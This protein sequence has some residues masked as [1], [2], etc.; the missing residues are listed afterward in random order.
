MSKKFKQLY[1]QAVTFFQQG[2]YLAAEPLFYQLIEMQPKNETVCYLL[3]TL[4]CQLAQFEEGV[5]FLKKVIEINPNQTDALNNLGLALATQGNLEEAEQCYRRALKLKPGYAHAWNN[6]GG[7]CDAKKD[8]HESILCYQKA[9]VLKANYS[10]ALYNLGKALLNLE[11]YGEAEKNLLQ[12]I[13]LNPEHY[14]ALNNMAGLLKLQNRA[15]QALPYLQTALQVNPERF[16]AYNNIAAIYQ[17]LNRS[18]DSLTYYDKALTIEPNGAQVHANR[19]VVLLSLGRLAEGWDEHEWRK[20]AENWAPFSYPEWQGED[21]SDKTIVVFAEQGVGD[22]ILFAS[23]LADLI[24]HA[25]LCIIECDPR[26]ETLYARSF[27]EAIVKGSPRSEQGWLADYPDIS[28]CTAIGSL[29]R[30]FRQS[31]NDFPSDAAV[32]SEDKERH[33]YW[34]KE[35]D[36]L[37]AGIKVGICWRSRLSKEGRHF[38][39][40]QLDDWGA[41]FKVPGVTFINLQYDECE[42]ELA[43]ANKL[44]GINIHQFDNI[45]LMNDLDDLVALS[46]CLDLVI[47][48]GT[49]TAELA[50]SIGTP[51]FRINPT[52]ID[53]G[54]LGTKKWP[55][56]PNTRIFHQ[57]EHEQWEYPLQLIADQ[58]ATFE[59]QEVTPHSNTNQMFSL[60]ETGQG[61]EFAWKAYRRGNLDTAANA[62]QQFMLEVPDNARAIE[63]Q[64]MVELTRNDHLKAENNFRR[65]IE[66]SPDTAVLYTR[67][68]KV[69]LTQGKQQEAELLFLQALELWSDWAELHNDLANL[70]YE[71]KRYSQ[72][73]EHYLLALRYK[74]DLV[75]AHN[76]LGSMLLELKRIDEAIR[77]F[78]DALRLKPHFSE[79]HYNLAN[80][81]TDKGDLDQAVLCFKKALQYKPNFSQAQL[82][83]AETYAK[84]GEFEMAVDHYI[85]LQQSEPD[86]DQAC[87]GL[88]RINVKQNNFAEGEQYYLKA[89]SLK[90]G[91]LEIYSEL[92][93]LF[94][95]QGRL[96]EA[97]AQ[98]RQAIKIDDSFYALHVNL[99]VILDA[100]EQYQEAELSFLKA[101]EIKPGSS[102]TYASLGKLFI[103]TRSYSEAEAYCRKAIELNPSS[104]LGYINLSYVMQMLGQ[105][106]Q[107]IDLCHQ[108]VERCDGDLLLFKNLIT[109]LFELGRF[110]ECLT[111]CNI[112]LSELPDDYEAL[113]CTTFSLLS[114]GELTPGWE[115][116][117]KLQLQHSCVREFSYPQWQGESLKGTLL[118]FAWQ[119]I[120]DELVFASCLPDVIDQ[121]G[122]C[123]I[124]CEPRLRGLYERSFPTAEVY[125]ANRDDK[126]WLNKVGTIDAQIQID[127]LPSIVRKTLSDFPVERRAYLQALPERCKYW[128]ERV[129]AIGPGL[130]IGIA[131]R[132]GLLTGGRDLYYSRIEHWKSVFAIPGV[133][134]INLQYDECAEELAQARKDFSVEITDFSE[135]NLKQDLEEAAALSS[136]MDIVISAGTA[137]AEIAA[138]I[139]VEVWRIEPFNLSWD[140]LG[141]GQMP[142]HS[143]MRIFKCPELGNW[144]GVLNEI[145]QEVIIYSRDQ[146]NKINH[147]N[148]CCWDL[149]ALSFTSST[150][151]AQ[152]QYCYQQSNWLEVR[153]LGKRLVSRQPDDAS[154]IHLMGKAAFKE[155][156]LADAQILMQQAQK[157]K[158]DNAEILYELGMVMQECR[159][160]KGA[161]ESYYS[162]LEIKPS[163]FQVHNNLGNVLVEQNQVDEAEKHY[164]SAI[165]LKPED[166]CG[167]NNLGVLLKKQNRLEEAVDCYRQSLSICPESY[168]V[169]AN[170]G[171]VLLDLGDLEEAEKC[172]LQAEKLNNTD[173]SVYSGLGDTLRE[174][175]R[176]PESLAY[177][178]KAIELDP[179]NDETRWNVA[180]TL[181]AMGN[182]KEGW[183][184]YEWRFRTGR[185]NRQFPYPEWDGS[186]L[187]RQKLL[188]YAEQ[189]IG[190]EILFASCFNDLLDQ[191]NHCVIECEPRLE[192]LYQ[193]SFPRAEIR[194]E[195]RKDHNWLTEV[196][197]IDWQIPNGSLPLYLRP[198]FDSFPKQSRYL[199]ADPERIA[200]WLNTLNTLDS[201]LKVGVIWRSGVL[202]GRRKRR[203]S[204]LSEWAGVLSIPG[205]TFFN[206][207]YGEPEEELAMLERQQGIRLQN[208][209]A[210]D[211][212]QDIDELA[213]CIS[214]LDLVIGPGTTTIALAAAL[215]KPVWKLDPFMRSFIDFGTEYIP[216]YSNINVFRQQHWNDWETPLN[217]ISEALINWQHQQTLPTEVLEYESRYGNMKIAQTD[218]ILADSLSRYGEFSQLRMELFA[219]LLK[220]GSIVLEIGAG[221]GLCALGLAQLVGENGRILACEA[222]RE[223]FDNL[224]L[225]V[226]NK[227]LPQLEC[228]PAIIAEQQKTEALWQLEYPRK[229]D[230]VES[231]FEKSFWNQKIEVLTIDYFQLSCCDL[232]HIDAESREIDA[233]KGG[234]DTFTRCKPFIYIENF[235]DSASAG[236]I[237][238]LKEMGYDWMI[239]R[240]PLFNENN[241]FQNA[242]NAYEGI[243]KAAILATPK[244][245]FDA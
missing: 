66:L 232:V 168:K 190:D 2:N 126:S 230:L 107:A 189:G 228:Y 81:L 16:D 141:T 63:L 176:L 70:Y 199:Y 79:A 67:L 45:D 234:L 124:E 206:L 14:D 225:N 58:L 88:A 137:A 180:L 154:V 123:V 197:P 116:Y 161:E 99:A 185:V 133:H 13:E 240:V 118:V 22:E 8:Y 89:L 165:S 242:D 5:S 202:E 231:H 207:Q 151:F 98:L 204:E 146:K 191:V 186:T 40:S 20:Q 213:A 7:I 195:I 153:K 90:P 212:K 97:E 24:A 61:L 1:P 73:E 159:N 51:V 243:E 19:A 138:A 101:L 172:Y 184:A 121:V 47:S 135:I 156:D 201:N 53:W 129:K 241:F 171:N 87:L 179:D 177:Y 32:F 29:P 183:Q 217:N 37:G 188:V 74:S 109:S 218:F 93:D 96:E 214:A 200:H 111:Y 181:L 147:S 10:E 227:V 198:S 11:R 136:A 193:R 42:D 100:S 224:C 192:K 95:R 56:H 130:K 41:I 50:S 17:L 119:G 169:H 15:E 104:S 187:A 160:F 244:L 237:N 236:I 57:L 75:E 3:G 71:Q 68:A 48:A 210:V 167:Y 117:S 209:A 23:C 28:I 128:A 239:H 102:E 60:V 33:Q 34:S 114:M 94:K 43:S 36:K 54:A 131:W 215:G 78:Q 174:L 21:I 221:E 235:R 196:E 46:A 173:V 143:N 149:G 155:N 91:V 77:C 245:N 132:S 134:F 30:F 9:I 127:L 69:L 38:N 52:V 4:K 112:I 62:I 64:G 82:Y 92:A 175:N 194:A 59:T 65:A 233:L 222:G 49:A 208:F 205:I 18:E 27:P 55:W 115:K 164:R 72:A 113:K 157:L 31:I 142:W 162:A 83:L 106:Q 144:E 163:L 223:D 238:Q 103:Q 229:A 148:S 226:S 25:K 125:G 203:F 178:T 211:L 108:A 166:Y 140:L 39:Y 216:W 105:H 120:G 84:Q 182:L 110:S 6:L 158:P 44:F 85:R 12:V 220:A 76:N 122:R 139:D 145:A 219:Q 86:H 170:L 35:L 80:A 26:L 150:L 152:M